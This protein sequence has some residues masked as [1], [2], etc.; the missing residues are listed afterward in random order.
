[1]KPDTQAEWPLD[2]GGDRNRSRAEA[3]PA[4]SPAAIGIQAAKP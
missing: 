4:F 2:R 1:M 3:D